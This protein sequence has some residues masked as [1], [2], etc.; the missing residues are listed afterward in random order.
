MSDLLNDFP[1]VAVV[2]PGE[3]LHVA[4]AAGFKHK[5]L[6]LIMEGERNILVDLEDTIFIDSTGLGTLVS[7]LR[8]VRGHGGDLRLA[9]LN[10]DLLDLFMLT[11]LETVF[12]IG[13]T[14][15]QA[16][17]HFM[18]SGPAGKMTA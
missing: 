13:Q 2:S 8:L 14:R 9:N 6:D 7:L 12:E 1:R 11:R 18:L 10:D 3:Q 16:F 4:N 5:V 17:V 15:E